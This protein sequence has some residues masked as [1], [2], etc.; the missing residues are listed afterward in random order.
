VEAA[1]CI[2][3]R[4]RGKRSDRTH[5]IEITAGTKLHRITGCER[6]RVNSLHHQSLKQVAPGLSVSA[7]APDGIIEGVEIEDA[8][9]VVAVQ[10][11]PEEMFEDSS[12]ARR[13]FAAFVEAAKPS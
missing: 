9:F 6:L 5:E 3:H 13:L 7:V 2:E 12:E 4:Q 8:P 10:F 1:S 11:H